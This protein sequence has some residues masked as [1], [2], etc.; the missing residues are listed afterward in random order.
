MYA[1]SLGWSHLVNACGVKAEWFIP[2]WVADKTQKLC[3]P[4]T[5]AIPERI[6]GGYDDAL[7]T[8]RRLLYFLLLTLLTPFG[9]SSHPTHPC[10]RERV[11]G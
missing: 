8:N 9:H 10:R 4:L 3:D 6:G 11:G 2:L 7:Y 1:T 5:R